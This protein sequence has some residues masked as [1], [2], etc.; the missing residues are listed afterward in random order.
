MFTSHSSVSVSSFIMAMYMPSSLSELFC[1]M[2][3]TLG[4][5]ALLGLSGFCV[6]NC[7]I[8]HRLRGMTVAVCVGFRIFHTEI[9]TCHFVV[10]S[11]LYQQ[12]L[13][14]LFVVG[15]AVLPAVNDFIC[16]VVISFA[17]HMSRAFYSVKPGSLSNLLRVWSSMMPHTMRSLIRLSVSVPNSHDFALVLRLVTY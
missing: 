2:V 1:S 8:R 17:R 16:T 11:C 15:L 12:H 3:C 14:R 9:F 10:F 7:G 5:S 4:L 13:L 6:R